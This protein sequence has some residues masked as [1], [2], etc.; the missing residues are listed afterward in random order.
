MPAR[1]RRGLAIAARHT[2]EASAEGHVAAYRDVI[3]RPA[4]GPVHRPAK[5][6]RRVRSR[7]GGH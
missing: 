7:L 1:R 3:G 5:V 6:S 2:W 4:R